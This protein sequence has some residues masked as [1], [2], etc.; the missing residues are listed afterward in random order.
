[1]EEKTLPKLR[2]SKEE[3]YQQIEAQIEKGKQFHRQ[4]ISSE[5]DLSK[6]GLEGIRVRLEL[7]DEP[8]PSRRTFGDKIFIVHGHDEA[9]KH[10]IARFI[11]DTDITSPSP[12]AP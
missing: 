3:A 6:I 1:M 5:D 9:A 11:A 10:E 2:V 4:Q 7:F 8:D 12:S